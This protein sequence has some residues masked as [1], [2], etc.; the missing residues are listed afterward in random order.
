MI[1]EAKSKH[2]NKIAVL[3]REVLS[4]TSSSRLGFNFVLNQYQHILSDKYSKIWIY[5]SASKITG[6]ISVS[7]KNKS[8]SVGVIKDVGLKYIITIFFKLLIH[9]SEIITL[10][11]RIIFDFKI[12]REFG[13]VPIIM[14][15][16]VSQLERGR[17]IGTKLLNR[18]GTFFVKNGF[19]EYYVDTESDNKI[20]NIFYQ[21][22]HF[23]LIKT[24][25]GH[26][27]YRKRI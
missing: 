18:A 26:K 24:Y 12:I 10:I 25:M 1:L 6:F 16:G 19:K 15:L 8:T 5:R 17:G 23:K 2:L 3:H 13:N 21:Q 27:L 11:Q 7:I 20:A 14:T 9:P 22:N 4:N